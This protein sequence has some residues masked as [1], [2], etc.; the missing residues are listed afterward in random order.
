[1][2]EG[3]DQIDGCSIDEC[4][5]D[6]FVEY[7]FVFMVCVSGYG[8]K[9]DYAWYEKSDIPHFFPFFRYPPVYIKICR[10]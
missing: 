2:A 7:L 6:M 10:I 5:D 8:S 4:P 9:I 3:E 1:M